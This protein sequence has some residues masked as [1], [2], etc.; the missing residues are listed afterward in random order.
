[1]SWQ[2][3]RVIHVTIHEPSGHAVVTGPR[4]GL[5]ERLTMEVGATKWD[6]EWGGWVLD[7]L[8]KVAD[9]CTLAEMNG[10]IWK[11]HAW[12]PGLLEKRKAARRKKA[13]R[14]KVA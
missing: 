12:E 13:Q 3:E 7:N 14:G 8:T 6:K 9:L 5:W 1:M 10:L 2:S 11:E 4:D